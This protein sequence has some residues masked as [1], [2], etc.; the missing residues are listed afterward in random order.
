MKEINL[1]IIKDGDYYMVTSEEITGLILGGND[2]QKLLADAPAVI[3]TLV[4]MN[5]LTRLES[6][7]PQP[8]TGR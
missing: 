7:T 4:N 8:N 6:I 1:K 5:N 2:L 3:E